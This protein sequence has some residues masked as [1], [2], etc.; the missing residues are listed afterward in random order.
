MPKKDNPIKNEPQEADEDDVNVLPL[1]PE[2]TDEE[3]LP[4]KLEDGYSSGIDIVS[5][6][7][8]DDDGYA[9]DDSDYV[10]SI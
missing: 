10:G 6:P 3:T 1:K 7:G 2:V 4:P 8:N 9:H 5:N